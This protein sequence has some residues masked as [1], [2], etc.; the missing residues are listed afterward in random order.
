MSWRDTLFVWRGRLR[1][2]PGE[3]PRGGGEPAAAHEAAAALAWRGAW[4]GVE[5]GEVAR[6]QLPAEEV[7]EHTLNPNCWAL[8]RP[9][10]NLKTAGLW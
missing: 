2:A 6:A 3:A 1:E 8:T 10:S 9:S 5:A 4:V 7:R